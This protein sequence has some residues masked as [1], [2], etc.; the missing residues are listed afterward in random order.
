MNLC[1]HLYESKAGVFFFTPTETKKF[2]QNPKMSLSSHS[3]ATTLRK[4]SE[5]SYER[6]LRSSC[7]GRMDEHTDGREAIGPS[8]GGG[9]S[10]IISMNIL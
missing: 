4:K 3:E 6:I 2:R 5:N 8:A 1:F 7:N 10:I 9:E